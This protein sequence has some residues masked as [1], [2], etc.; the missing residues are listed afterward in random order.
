MSVADRVRDYC[1]FEDYR[2]NIA[3]R[4][5]S[6]LAFDTF[7]NIGGLNKMATGRGEIVAA[8]FSVMVLFVDLAEARFSRNNGT[9]CISYRGNLATS[10]ICFFPAC[11]MALLI[12]AESH[13]GRFEWCYDPFYRSQDN[14]YRL[15][16]NLKVFKLCFQ[17]I[18]ILL[19]F[20][21]VYT[22]GQSTAIKRNK[23]KPE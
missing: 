21:M 5:F 19:A 14:G 1:T 22:T 17:S 12:G 23:L 20:L 6:W 2:I 3:S 7:V 8:Y 4:V 15:E 16:R 11:Y 10:I 9:G 18:K 13:Q